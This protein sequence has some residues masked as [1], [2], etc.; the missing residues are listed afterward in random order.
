MLV[1]IYYLQGLFAAAPIS[2]LYSKQN[3]MPFGCTCL[4]DPLLKFLLS[5]GCQMCH[6]IHWMRNLPS[7]I[8]DWFYLF[9]YLFAPWSLVSSIK[10][11]IIY[12]LCNMFFLKKIIDLRKITFYIWCKMHD[13]NIFKCICYSTYTYIY[14]S[15]GI[16]IC[17]TPMPIHWNLAHV[18]FNLFPWI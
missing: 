12:V 4:F 1:R 11:M 16:W 2:T 8:C 14:A 15:H 9:I 17:F 5:N 13:K 18:K 3:Q 6:H 10:L 7:H